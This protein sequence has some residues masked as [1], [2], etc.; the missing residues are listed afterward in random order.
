LIRRRDRNT[1]G[2]THD[3]RIATPERFYRQRRL[4]AAAASNRSPGE[5]D[6][7]VAAHHL[8]A[9]TVEAPCAWRRA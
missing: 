6:I 5:R 3:R 8:V 7:E 1:V 2:E 4:T 9:S